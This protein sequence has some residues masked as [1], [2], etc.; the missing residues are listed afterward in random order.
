M[1]W[2]LTRFAELAESD[3]ENTLLAI[4]IRSIESDGLPNSHARCCEQAEER[5]GS[6]AGERKPVNLSE[7]FQ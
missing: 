5:G 3:G 2:N 6:C 1:E 7:A 4:K